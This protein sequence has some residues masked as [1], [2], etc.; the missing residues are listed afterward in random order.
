MYELISPRLL[1]ECLLML[2]LK[3][4]IIKKICKLTPKELILTPL[5]VTIVKTGSWLENLVEDAEA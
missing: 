3:D 5:E 4:Y 2:G 1:R